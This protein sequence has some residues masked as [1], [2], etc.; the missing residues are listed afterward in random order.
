MKIWIIVAVV[1]MLVI[2]GLVAVNA[3]TNNSE[4]IGQKEGQI[5]C[6]S[7]GNSCTAEKNC[8]QASCGAINGMGC[9][10]GK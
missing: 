4:I 6:S 2:V 1:A 7:C 10:C 8:G 5:K 3:L 9:S